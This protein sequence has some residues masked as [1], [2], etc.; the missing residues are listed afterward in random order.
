MEPIKMRNEVKPN[1]PFR[2]TT[3]YAAVPFSYYDSNTSAFVDGYCVGPQIQIPT[4]YPLVRIKRLRVL[5][6]HPSVR[7]YNQFI[8]VYCEFFGNDINGQKPYISMAG[9]VDGG[10]I[11]V[12]CDFLISPTT[13]PSLGVRYD[14]YSWAMSDYPTSAG[15]PVS[16]FELFIGLE[17]IGEYVDI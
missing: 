7:M 11:F 8:K 6:G 10:E 14:C 5:L 9:S 13:L 4:T 15:E 12:D 2:F 16:S 3:E 1:K 17:I